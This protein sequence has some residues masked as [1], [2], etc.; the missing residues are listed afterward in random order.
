M[1]SDVGRFNGP[2]GAALEAAAKVHVGD[3]VAAVDQVRMV[4]ALS[5]SLR[6]RVSRSD[7]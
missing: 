2:A 5:S 7:H 3:M 6:L 1:R 4:A